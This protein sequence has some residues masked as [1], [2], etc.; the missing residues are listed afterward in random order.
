MEDKKTPDLDLEHHWLVPQSITLP[1]DSLPQTVLMRWVSQFPIADHP[2]WDLG[3]VGGEGAG[4]IVD[5]LT[6]V[7]REGGKGEEKRRGEGRVRG[8]EGMGHEHGCGWEFS[9]R[10]NDSMFLG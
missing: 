6:A 1:A 9:V 8:K 5:T 7:H 4:L 3:A 10:A 2:G